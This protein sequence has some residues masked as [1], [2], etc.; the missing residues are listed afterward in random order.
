MPNETKHNKTD[1]R[2]SDHTDHDHT[3]K[4]REGEG[5]ASPSATATAETATV[6]ESEPGVGEHARLD[7]EGEVDILRMEILNVQGQL[8]EAQKQAA[9]YKD[10]Y[11]R[12]RAELENYRRRAAQDNE[13]AREA[14]V[15][16]AIFAVLP[17]YDDLG[18]ALQAASDDPAKIIPGVETVREGLKRNLEALGIKEVGKQGERFDPDFHEALSSFPAEDRALAG[19][20]AEVFQVGFTKGERLVRPARVVVYQE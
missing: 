7:A 3:D 9:D 11:L 5:N 8:G 17:A 4:V 16:S 2:D 6:A 14:G 18:R 13:R 10:K 15:D 19:T 1:H 12:A 20:I